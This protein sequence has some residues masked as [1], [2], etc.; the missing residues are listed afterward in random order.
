[1]VCR[2]WPEEHEAISQVSIASLSADMLEHGSAGM[3]KGQEI[4]YHC[5]QTWQSM[6]P[7]RLHDKTL[8]CHILQ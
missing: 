6:G 8:G 2:T 1:M 3:S 4:C 5:Q 7:M